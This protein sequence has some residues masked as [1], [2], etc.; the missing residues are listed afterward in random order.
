MWASWLQTNPEKG[1][2]AYFRWYSPTKAF[3]PVHL[4]GVPDFMPVPN[5]L[6]RFMLSSYSKLE[7]NAD[8][9]LTLMLG[10]E[11]V[12]GVPEANW[13]PTA[14]GHLFSLNWRAY[15]P[16][17]IVRQGNWFPPAVTIRN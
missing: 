1:F 13:L 3:W 14:P 2:F 5:R 7:N 15:I 16:K 6:D 10:P 12:A 4:D 11:P 17:E 9:S 8:G